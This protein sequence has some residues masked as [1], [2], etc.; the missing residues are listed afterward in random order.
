MNHLRRDDVNEMV[1]VCNSLSGDQHRTKLEGEMGEASWGVYYRSSI[2]I[3]QTSPGLLY[4]NTGTDCKLKGR[5]NSRLCPCVMTLVH[6]IFVGSESR[7][8]DLRTV[9]TARK[10][11]PTVV[12]QTDMARSV[13]ALVL[14]SLPRCRSPSQYSMGWRQVIYSVKRTGGGT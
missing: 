5:R 9:S 1:F 6:S 10:S 3:T 14:G 4:G 8:I 7:G 11:Q 13:A 2:L 12:Y